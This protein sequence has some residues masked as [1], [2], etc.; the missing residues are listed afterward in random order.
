MNDMCGINSDQST[1]RWL[2]QMRQA[3]SLQSISYLLPGALPWASMREAVGLF[4]KANGLHLKANDLL[5]E[6]NGLQN[7]RYRTIT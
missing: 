5:P 3:F 2:P 6:A 1:M 7:H 4:H